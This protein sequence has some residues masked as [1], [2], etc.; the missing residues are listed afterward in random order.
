MRIGHGYDV[1]KFTKDRDLVLGGVLIDFEMGL[2]AHSDGDVLIHSL[3]DS[4]LGALCLGDIGHLF[5]DTD[6]TYKNISSILLLKKVY[7]KMLDMRYVISNI[8][9]TIVCQEPKLNKY[10][11]DMRKLISNEL[12]CNLNDVNIKA[13]TEEKL[14]FTGRMEGISCHCV[15]LLK[16]V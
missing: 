8:D 15:S 9:I 16:K 14:G 10:I 11:I 12:N 6:K 13:T 3:I 4:L 2:E 5:P 7:E 1:H